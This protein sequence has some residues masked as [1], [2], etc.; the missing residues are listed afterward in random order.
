MHSGKVPTYEAKISG[1]VEREADVAASPDGISLTETWVR[2][3]THGKANRLLKKQAER[4]GQNFSWCD[5]YSW[6][7][8]AWMESDRWFFAGVAWNMQQE[9]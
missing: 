7:L 5:P 2:M 9:L 1:V 4:P 6:F 3:G 8:F